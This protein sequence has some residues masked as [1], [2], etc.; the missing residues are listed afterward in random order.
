MALVLVTGCNCRS[1][2]DAAYE[3][4]NLFQVHATVR[5]RSEINGN[6]VLIVH[7]KSKDDD[8]N[9]RYLSYKQQFDWTFKTILFGNTLFWCY[10]SWRDS[11]GK[12]YEG[13][14]D[15]YDNE[16][17][18]CGLLNHCVLEYVADNHHVILNNDSELGKKGEVWVW[19]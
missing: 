7:C 6:H 11:N 12:L 14:F 5:V 16:E 4:D 10:M 3:V 1:F 18:P 13:H 17:I 15:V 8:L 2:V 9:A 19:K